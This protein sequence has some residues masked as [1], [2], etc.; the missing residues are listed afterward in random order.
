MGWKFRLALRH[1][2]GFRSRQAVKWMNIFAFAGLALSVFAWLT[3]TSVMT[4]MQNQIKDRVLAN[5][6]HVTWEG[7]PRTDYDP[8][9]KTIIDSVEG[10]ES[11]ELSLRSEALVE[12][13]MPD[14]GRSRQSGG[15]LEGIDDWSGPSQDVSSDY[16]G[17]DEGVKVPSSLAEKLSVMKGEKIKIRSAWNLQNFPL[18]LTVSEIYDDFEGG[19]MLAPIFLPR[20]K[21]SQWLELDNSYSWIAIRLQDSARA[22]E[23]VS[24]LNQKTGLEF[25]SW[26]AVDSALWYSLRLEKT[27]MSLA[28]FFVLILSSFALYMAISVR[29]AEKLKELALLR[30]LG[31]VS[32]DLRTLFLMQGLF[33]GLVGS[34]AGVL[35][36]YVACYAL[37]NLINLPSFYY[38]TNVPVDWQWT[39]VF[40]S[41]LVVLMLSYLSTCFPVWRALKFSISDTLRS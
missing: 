30:A 25:K 15:I 33:I 2:S 4:G 40:Y 28:V 14:T 26:E 16:V 21:L 35:L 31:A 9:R 5:K 17:S 13:V 7:R 20:K 1:L 36:S 38:S 18:S 37:A 11:V 39:R 8:I 24:L 22:T 23:V 32:S 3:I 34:V 29:L 41:I 12:F 19:E 10:L 6:P 27:V